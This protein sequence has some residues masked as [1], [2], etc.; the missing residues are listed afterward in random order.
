MYDEEYYSS[1]KLE[2]GDDSIPRGMKEQTFCEKLKRLETLV[3]KGRILDV[4]CATGF[5][6]D[7]AEKRGWEAYGVEISNYAAGVAE[8][9]HPGRVFFGSL[10]RA[11]FAPGMFDAV[12]LF[13]LI[14]H[15]AEPRPF[16]SR[17]SGLLREGGVL[18]L[19]TPD[20]SSLSSRL[21]KTDWSHYKAEHLTYFSPETICRLLEIS[22]IS[23]LAVESSTKYLNLRY[24]SGQLSAYPHTILTP[25][26]RVVEKMIPEAFRSVNF[27]VHCGE[28]LVLARKKGVV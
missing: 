28:M 18:L 5:F 10:D 2:E 11:G 19:V 22:G 9:R 6:L 13:D 25:L 16:M 20:V 3:D 23:P 15:I 12:T 26:V 14:E 8:R 17:V 4:G 21:M 1:W 24:V 27:R 7:V